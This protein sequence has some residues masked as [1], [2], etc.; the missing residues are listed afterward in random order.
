MVTC[1]TLHCEIFDI[2]PKTA[3]FPT[4]SPRE[5]NFQPPTDITITIHLHIGT[6]IVSIYQHKRP[7]EGDGGFLVLIGIAIHGP[8]AIVDHLNLTAVMLT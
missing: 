3:T 2:L 8:L 5:R 7:L 4:T 1:L 6:E